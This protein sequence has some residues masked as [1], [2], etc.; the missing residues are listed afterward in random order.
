MSGSLRVLL[1]GGHPD[2]VREMLGESGRE[3]ALI[4]CERHE[5]GI[6]VVSRGDVEVVLLD[7]ELPG[8]R[9]TA[10]FDRLREAA[11]DVPII[12]LTAVGDERAALR[13][14]QCGA[15]DYLVKGKTDADL[16]SR[17]VRY[18]QE[19]MRAERAL[20]NSEAMYR[21]LVENLNEGVLA[22]DED[23]IITFANPRMGEILGYPAERLPGSPVARFFGT[24]DGTASVAKNLSCRQTDLKQEF[25]QDLLASD[26]KRIHALVVSSPIADDAGA[27][28]GCLAGVLDI[29]GRKQAEE[30]L[31]QSEQKYRLVVESL[32]EGIWVIDQDT[33][34]SFVNPRMAEMLGYAPEEMIGKPFCSFLSPSC[35][36]V[37]Q[38]RLNRR[39]DG[40]REQYECEFVRK[41]GDSITALLIAS[42]FTDDS[43]EFRGSIAGVMDITERKQAEEEIRIRNEQLM[44]LNQIISVSATSLSLAELLEESLEKTLDLMGFHVGVVYMLDAERKRALLQYQ[45]G[46]PPGCMSRNRVIKVH[47]WPFNF[48]FIAGQPRYIERQPDLN[49]IEADILRELEVSSLACIPLIAESVV[50]GAVYVGSKTKESFSREERTLLEMIGKEIGSGILK[51]MLH[52]KLEAAN[53]EANLYLDI[54]THDIKNVENVASLY[55]DLLIEML[56]GGE[57]ALYAKKIRSSIRKSAEILGNVTTIRRIHHDLPVTEPV[58]LDAVVREE[59]AAFPD[60]A[61]EFEDTPRRVWADD[62][63]SE[64]FTN[65]IRNAVKFGGPGVRITVKME[66][67]D[68]EN[69]LVSVEDTGPGI[70]DGMKES[71]FH[72]FERGWVAG[73]GDGLGLFIVRTLIERYG[74]TVRVEDRVEG[75][76]DL[77]AAFRFTLREVLPAGGDEDADELPAEEECR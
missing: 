29:T 22:V 24:A 46:V 74:G 6:A 14:M 4:H 17:A 43:G 2:D 35:G 26:G 71:I 39:R 41:D 75:R 16:L 8:N 31:R 3:V 1:I 63:L 10:L 62:L 54:M 33:L 11:P 36:A 69:V 9:E 25:E 28:R 44:V 49:S 65:L 51:G 61:I 56:G 48:I 47:H 12:V 64:V 40:I 73:C 72:R 76:P 55:A 19:R 5:S 45:R 38:D 57:A 37:I 21:R 50:V 15:Q 59:V 52:K 18:A 67:Y 66:D 60:V 30:A 42:P 68:G 13:A 53:R 7:L 77:G 20:R 32:S 27:F 34:T 70:P 23:G 58:D